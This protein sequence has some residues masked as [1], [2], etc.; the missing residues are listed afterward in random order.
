M[1][2]LFE[3]NRHISVGGTATESQKPIFQCYCKKACKRTSCRDFGNNFAANAVYDV[4]HNTTRPT[5]NT[6]DQNVP[7]LLQISI[8]IIV[9]SKHGAYHMHI[10]AVVQ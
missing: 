9:L 6:N 10:N 2:V 1:T 8:V 4:F 5:R 7:N 3:L